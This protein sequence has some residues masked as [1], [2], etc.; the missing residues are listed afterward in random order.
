MPRDSDY[1]IGLNDYRDSHC[2]QHTRHYIGNNMC[3]HYGVSSSGYANGLADINYRMG[4]NSV[5]GRDTRVDNMI[6][7]EVFGLDSR[8]GFNSGYSYDAA[9]LSRGGINHQQQLDRIGNQFDRAGE[10]YAATGD[11]AF[12]AMQRDL[13]SIAGDHLN[14]DLR[15]FR[16]RR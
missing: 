14:A 7:R 5:N 9:Q 8:G 2:G 13:R 1:D 15:G 3:Q 10:A 16:L 4:S 6:I 12:L 11:R